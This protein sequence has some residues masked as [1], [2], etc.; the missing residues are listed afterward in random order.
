MVDYNITVP[1]P[2]DQSANIA[3]ALR[4]RA[5][6]QAEAE[7]QLKTQAWLEDRA[8]QLEQRKA[9][10]AAAAAG[11]AKAAEIADIYSTTAGVSPAAVGA[12][13]MSYSDTGVSSDPYAT[14]RNELIK[15][16]YVSQAKDIAE[17]QNKLL[18][19]EKSSA[20][21]TKL[22]SET[23]GQD[24]KNVGERLSTVQRFAGMVNSPEEAAAYSRMLVK[25]FPEFASLYGTPDDA[26]QRSADAFKQDP[27]AWRMHS[28]NLTPEQLVQA[29]E[30]ETAAVQP[31]LTEMD[32]GG[33]KLM[34]D[35]NPRSPTYNQAVSEFDKTL[36]PAEVSANQKTQWEQQ[37]PDYTLQETAQGLIAVNKK[38][39]SDVQPVQLG[40]QTVMPFNKS[41]VT[42]INTNL[43][44]SEQAQKDYMT[45]V[46]K[47]RE[48]L[49]SAPGTLANIEK[50]KELIP[51]AKAFLGT[52]GQGLLEATKFFNNRLGTNINAEGVKN[53]E[54][55][56]SRLFM[57]VMDNLKKM[58]AQPTG[59]Q[60]E[61]LQEAIG[62][63]DTDPNALPKILDI[64]GDSLRSKVDVYNK[65]VSEAESRGVKFPYKPQIDLPAKRGDISVTTPDGK[66]HTFPTPEAAAQFKKAA[67]IP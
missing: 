26:A 5:Q 23:K 54:E 16:G 39:P 28:L 47:T 14:T 50:A 24:L 18:A 30:R 62:Q 61:A 13:G 6:Q 63:L 21:T 58:D 49:Q 37:N 10:A 3:N 32:V 12:R 2:Y 34:V 15:R 43:P 48:A 46:A 57:G 60:Q 44:A 67:G 17:Y 9:A 20:E 29:H 42:N 56:R 7:N 8:Y 65:D 35:T 66:V 40:G 55:L 38:N 52:G 51:S 1:Q 45:N 53:A 19:N 33:T 4:F 31:K 59:R 25:E 41:P 27:N 22:G 11:R 64:L 36:T